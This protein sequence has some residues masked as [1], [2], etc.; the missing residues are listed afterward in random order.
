MF[1]SCNIQS[2]ITESIEN[3]T[4]QPP[5]SESPKVPLRSMPVPQGPRRAPPPRKKSSQKQTSPAEAEA[6]TLLPEKDT[7]IHDISDAIQTA[8][9]PVSGHVEPEVDAAA[10][11]NAN[12]CLAESADEKLEPTEQSVSIT[13]QLGPSDEARPGRAPPPIPLSPPSVPHSESP[14]ELEVDSRP[15]QS[16]VSPDDI[17][18]L[19][20]P[21]IPTQEE[22]EVGEVVVPEPDEAPVAPAEEDDEDETARRHRIAER[23]AKTGGFNPFGGQLMRSPTLGDEPPS[24]EREVSGEAIPVESEETTLQGQPAALAAPSIPYSVFQQGGNATVLD[25]EGEDDDGNDGKY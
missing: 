2:L 23:V 1:L 4:S 18:E 22:T 6:T 5:A 13:S 10:D 19:A 15:S 14:D 21:S 17:G 11:P 8:P 20:V 12:V 24:V 9:I 16:L 25:K 7:A 3:A